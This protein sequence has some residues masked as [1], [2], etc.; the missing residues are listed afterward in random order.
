MFGWF[1]QVSNLEASLHKIHAGKTM[2]DTGIQNF[3]DQIFYRVKN[4][5]F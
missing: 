1:R 5:C 4:L 3:V 2:H